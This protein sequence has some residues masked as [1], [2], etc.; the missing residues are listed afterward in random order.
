MDKTKE[1]VIKEL[2]E[3]YKLPEEVILNMVD[4]QFSFVIKA[5]KEFKETKN[6]KIILLPKFG[7]FA[8]SLRKIKMYEINKNTKSLLELPNKTNE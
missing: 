6:Y 8:P 1:L 5:L 3:K 7:K 4:S 2:A